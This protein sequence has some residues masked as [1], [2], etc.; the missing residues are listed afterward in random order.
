ME[1]SSVSPSPQR[2][3]LSV[4]F[5]IP[6]ICL[7][8]AFLGYSIPSGTKGDLIAEL[9]FPVCL[10]VMLA[11]AVLAFRPLRKAINGTFFQRN[12]LL[13]LL[14]LGLI[15][16][17]NLADHR[18]NK[19]LL[20][21][22]VI[23]ATAMHL[24]QNNVYRTPTFAHNLAN[25][26]FMISG[27]P[28]KRPPLYPF[29]LSLLHRILG[30]SQ[31]NGYILNSVLGFLFLFLMGKA[32]ELLYPRYGSYIAVLSL[33]SLPLLSQNVTSQHLEVLYIAL[34]AALLLTCL[35]IAV[36][37]N[38]GELA[39][40]YLLAAALAL[41]RY[42]G[43]LFF[44][45]PFV[46]HVYVHLAKVPTGSLRMP[47][48]LCPIT[49]AYL[50]ML[51]SYVFGNIDFW[52]LEDMNNS[53]PFGVSYWA[54]NTGAFLDFA[55]NT[56]RKLPGSLP[57]SVLGIAAL[58]ILFVLIGRKI[59]TSFRDRSLH[60]KGPVVAMTALAVTFLLFVVLIISY[61][62]GHVND[63][64]TARFLLF[65]LL[66]ITTAILFAFR[67]EPVLTLFLAVVLALL[68]GIQACWLKDLQLG[69]SYF[70]VVGGLA[71][72]LGLRMRQRW[73]HQFEPAILLFWSIYI[74]SETLPAINQRSYESS[75]YPISRTKIFLDW[76]KKDAGTNT[77]FVAESAF[78]GMVARENTTS[79]DRLNAE[80]KNLQHLLDS[81]QFTKVIVMQE[82]KITPKGEF[83]PVEKWALL[84]KFQYEV[85]ENIRI[86][87]DFGVRK[88]RITDVGNDPESASSE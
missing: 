8:G 4:L 49:V 46:M 87:P 78:Y 35:R 50:F 58:P 59:C 28:D 13:M 77:V 86:T 56:S 79:I 57:L 20:D 85:L 17:Y 12:A 44:A 51:V 64:L 82:A 30:Y 2:N 53:T 39:L 23:Q 22:L 66:F 71:I 48:I 43:L 80:S 5:F 24:T 81:N 38:T 7:V 70:L 34:G 76:I 63:H 52:Q 42:E 27:P 41:A 15:A 25:E 9:A 65:P 83:I 68:A 61:H 75:Y 29:L 19:V 37:G 10:L 31:A 73:I 1:R 26:Y 45:V 6:L 21:E 54:Q 67:F 60:W 11:I 18:A 72:A 84:E 16:I 36:N 69:F 47:L 33:A 3:R 62:W 55:L 74:L 88:I 14:C 32:G 40:A